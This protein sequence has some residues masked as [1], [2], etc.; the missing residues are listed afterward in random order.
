[1]ILT[2][3]S[4]SQDETHRSPLPEFGEGLGVGWNVYRF[5]REML[6]KVTDAMIIV[7][8]RIR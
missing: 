7:P 6:L 4:Q 5:R 8:V 1:M 2:R 3:P